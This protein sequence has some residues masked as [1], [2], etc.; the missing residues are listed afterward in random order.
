MIKVLGLLAVVGCAAPLFATAVETLEVSRE[1][2]V[3]YVTMIFSINAPVSE[4]RPMLTDYAS[5]AALNPAI[6]ESE[7]LAPPSRGIT[8]VQTRLRDC[9]W[10]LCADIER[11][12]DVTEARADGLNA[13]VVP[14]L[15]D[16]ASGHTYVRFE[17]TGEVTRIVFKAD[18]EPRFWVPP[19]IG[20]LL[21]ERRVSVQLSH[22][23]ANLER[24][25]GP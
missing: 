20:P 23:V 25:V 5:L 14:A 3:Y 2:D 8:R 9:I 15:S 16:M 13:A 7:V 1:G 4:V 17:P 22:T 18:M 11:V 12:D 10:F 19:L 24:L 21:I 6:V